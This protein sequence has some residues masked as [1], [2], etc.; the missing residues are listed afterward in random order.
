VLLNPVFLN[1]EE[2]SQAA[3]ART[4]A[5]NM[6]RTLG[7]G[8]AGAE[9]AAIVTIEACTNLLKH[10][11]GGSLVLSPTPDLKIELVVMDRGPGME[12]LAEC[13]TD[14]FSTAGTAGT[15][16][17]AIGRLSAF[18][19]AYS[20]P[21]RG[22]VVFAVLAKGEKLKLPAPRVCGIQAPKPG[23]E[24]C[25]DAWAC[26]ADRT[27]I[28][29]VIADGLGHGPDAAAAARCAVD[30]FERSDLASPKEIL[31]SIH[32]GSR[33]T[34]G[35]AVTVASLDDQRHI[36]E[37]AGL[38]NVSGLVCERGG[39]SRQM[40]T[41]NGTAGLESR[42]VFRE[43]SYPWPEGSAVVLHSDGLTSH[44]NLSEFP[45]LIS[46]GAALVA[47]VLFRDFRRGSDD[48]TVVAIV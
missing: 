23:Q 13:L 24:V 18:S 25:G 19:D 46:R 26:R 28:T 1:V 47:G 21:G 20:Q 38:G 16:L 6:A 44:W 42:A 9:R 22:T 4:A 7:F 34:R 36:V 41:M 31:E 3:E 40:V 48:A 2:N 43:F 5:R 15:G 14:G 29:V 45:G 8:E 11:G 39:G 12:S 30:I 17:G 10:A 32:L 27:R 33:H 37:F 35:A